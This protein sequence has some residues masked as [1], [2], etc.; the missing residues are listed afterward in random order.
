MESDEAL[1]RAVRDGDLACLTTL[2][3]RY[4]RPLFGFLYRMTGSRATAED[5]V[6]DVFVRVLK[7]RKTYRDT[8]SFE[9]WLFHIARNTRH[10]FAKKHPAME[11]ISDD[12]DVAATGPSP[13]LRL[14]QHEDAVLLKDAL[15]R[16]PADKR[17]LIILAR[18]RGMSYAQLGALMGADV[19]TIRVRL[20]R[21]VRQLEEIFSQLRGSA[22]HAL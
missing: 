10:D 2:F 18:Y 16:L 4:H 5:L 15:S 6:Q 9:A 21:A 22:R 13:G 17:E 14:E 1:M 20:H 3:E 19:G 12:M 7:Y 8:G 11:S